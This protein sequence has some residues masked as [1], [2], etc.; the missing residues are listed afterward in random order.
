MP[1][2]VYSFIEYTVEVGA[3]FYAPSLQDYFRK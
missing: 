3:V 1:M 2:A